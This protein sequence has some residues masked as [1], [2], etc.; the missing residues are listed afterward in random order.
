MRILALLLAVS[1]A[2]C[3]SSLGMER[4]L[5]SAVSEL[6]RAVWK[7]GLKPIVKPEKHQPL[8]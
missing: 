8:K 7:D 5:N 1:V 6:D 4:D 2:A 3:S